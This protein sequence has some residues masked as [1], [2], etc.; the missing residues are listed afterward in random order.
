[1]CFADKSFWTCQTRPHILTILDRDRKLSHTMTFFIPAPAWHEGNGRKSAPQ[2]PLF[3]IKLL[4][5]FTFLKRRMHNLSFSDL[6]RRIFYTKFF[7]IVSISHTHFEGYFCCKNQD[8]GFNE[9]I[10]AFRK[11]PIKIQTKFDDLP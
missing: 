4:K 2:A 5:P 7:T 10:S 11:I 3:K 1:M 6:G 9:K 8:G